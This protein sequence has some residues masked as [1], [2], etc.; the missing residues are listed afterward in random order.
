MTA[1]L[2]KKLTV[3]DIT[4]PVTPLYVSSIG[5]IS[6]APALDGAY[7]LV[8][9]GSYLYTASQTSDAVDVINITNPALPVYTTRINKSSTVRLD[10]VTNLEISGN[11]LYATSVSDDALEILNITNPAL[12]THA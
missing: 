6:G 5:T 12:P 11:Y 4:N 2:A 3:I 8:Y 1:F 7:G 10:G 9:S